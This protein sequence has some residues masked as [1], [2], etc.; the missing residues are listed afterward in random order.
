VI[1]LFPGYDPTTQLRPNARKLVRKGRN[2]LARHG[3]ALRVDVATTPA[4]VLQLLPEVERAHRERDRRRRGHSDLDRPE[5][6]AFW[7]AIIAEAATRG[8]VEITTLRVDDQLGAHLVA[9]A[10][11]PAYRAW[12]LRISP[13]F[14]FYNLGHVIRDEV[15]LRI[16]ASGRFQLFDWM[17]GVEDYKLH[18]ATRVIPSETLVGW[19]AT[20]LRRA[21]I[22]AR[23]ADGALRRARAGLVQ[24]RSRRSGRNVS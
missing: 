18:T 9:F 5:F 20:S 14:D 13:G 16:G 24:W 10:D 23:R 7:H 22:A 12:D 17:R 2:R 15:L 8:L 3:R 21:E 11:G 19:S 1:D 4:D 6:R